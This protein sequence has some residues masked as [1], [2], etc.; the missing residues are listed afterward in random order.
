MEVWKKIKYKD[1]IDN[2]EISTSGN[3]RKYDTKKL[4]KVSKAA[5]GYYLV[6]L[7][8]KSG[9]K[10]FY[11]HI[12]VLVTFS[13]FK[14]IDKVTVNH[15]DGKK[16]NNSLENLEWANHT[17]QRLHA[18][19]IGLRDTKFDEQTVRKV[20][21]YLEKGFKRKEIQSILEIENTKEFKSLIENIK[22]KNSWYH[23]SKGYNIFTKNPGNFKFSKEC[24]EEICI[25]LEKGKNT[26]EISKILNLDY[27]KSFKDLVYNIRL[28]KTWVKISNKYKW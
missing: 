6:N 24:I 9:W 1:I 10:T 21:S 26:K 23:I 2:Y 28:R 16:Y 20:C 19:K 5:N 12:L 15:I 8:T 4:L 14:K 17:E 22:S 25:L 11:I 27:N 13:L 18:Y 3:I 7:K